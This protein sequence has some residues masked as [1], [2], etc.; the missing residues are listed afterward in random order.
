MGYGGNGREISYY[1]NVPSSRKN[2][3]GTI[4]RPY[5]DNKRNYFLSSEGDS[6]YTGTIVKTFGKLFFFFG[7]IL[8]LMSN[9]KTILFRMS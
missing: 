9:T 6:L 2:S 4:S 5:V 3:L 7:Q 8:D 1:N